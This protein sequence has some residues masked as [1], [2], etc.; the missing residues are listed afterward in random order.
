MQIRFVKDDNNELVISDTSEW[1]LAKDGLEGFSV[2]EADLTTTQ[3]YARD[4]ERLEHIRLSGKTRTISICNTDWRNAEQ[5]R[6]VLKDFFLYNKLYKIYI[7][8]GQV[9]RWVEG[10]LYRMAFNE[11][12][13][14][15]YMLKCTMSFE[16]ESPFLKSVD[17]FGKDIAALTPRF[18]FPWISEID[19]GLPVAVFDFER[20]VIL[21]NLGDNVAYPIIKV[22]FFGEVENPQVNINDGFIR[23]LGTY[24]TTDNITIDYTQNPP[25]I[26]N[27][28]N[29]IIGYCDRTS[30]FDNMLLQVGSNA[31]S[32]SA[33][34]GTDEMSV[35]I[36]YY[37][38]YTS[39]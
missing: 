17:D 5:N 33:D 32:F 23:I 26:E 12:T 13:N 34:D 16:F 1:R 19:K 36:Y 9:T 27:N 8:A 11:P 29:N 25:R 10:T 20:E 22:S 24:N 4:G 28:G 18:G 3:D 38:L 31:V 6:E 7:S 14:Q 35:S 21:S 15:D 2:F 30:D 37:Q 39:V